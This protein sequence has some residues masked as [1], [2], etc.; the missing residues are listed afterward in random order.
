MFAFSM[1]CG[2]LRTDCQRNGAAHAGDTPARL[3]CR[4]VSSNR[5][6]VPRIPEVGICLPGKRFPVSLPEGHRRF[7]CRCR[8]ALRRLDFMRRRVDST[9]AQPGTREGAVQCRYRRR[10]P[11]GCLRKGCPRSH[12]AVAPRF[13]DGVIGAAWRLRNNQRDRLFGK[14]A[15]PRC[16]A[17]QYQG[18]NSSGAKP[19][20]SGIFGRLSILSP[21]R[22]CPLLSALTA[23]AAARLSMKEIQ[24]SV[25]QP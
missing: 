17:R 4:L 10:R 1:T 8:Q 20:G 15:S 18:Q 11:D 23:D 21:G 14:S 25:K 19:V 5:H 12:L 16:T 7:F 9:P 2:K 13:C 22:E 3:P 6:V 24:C